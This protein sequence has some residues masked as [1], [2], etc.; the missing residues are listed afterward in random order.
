MQPASLQAGFQQQRALTG[1]ELGMGGLAAEQAAQLGQANLTGNLL[2]S[3]ATLAAAQASQEGGS[4]LTLEGL[5]KD[6]GSWF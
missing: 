5:L 2:T 3:L 6:I 4:G 1:A